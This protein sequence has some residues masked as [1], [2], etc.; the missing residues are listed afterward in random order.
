M[1][2]AYDNMDEYTS[3]ANHPKVKALIEQLVSLNEKIEAF[4][5][6]LAPLETA[7]KKAEKDY[8]SWEE[9]MRQ[10]MRRRRA[11]VTKAASLAE[12]VRRGLDEAKRL[13]VEVN[14]M[15]GA[16]VQDLEAHKR[17]SEAEERWEQIMADHEWLWKE[18]IRPFQV[19]AAKFMASAFDNQLHGVLNADQMG[20][21][22]TLMAEAALDLVQSSDDYDVVMSKRVDGWHN[23]KPM[24]KKAVLWICPN[25]IKVTT[26]NELAKW[27]SNRMVAVLDGPPG[28]RDNIVKIAHAN[29]LTLVVNYETLSRTPAI[30]QKAWPIVVLDEAHTFKNEGTQVFDNVEK[31]C[32]KAGLIY[33]MTGT[34]ITNRP[35]EFWAILHMLTLKGKYEGKFSA[36]W[37]Y[38]NEYCYQ[39]GNVI[40]FRGNSYDRLI[41]NVSNMVIR[42]RKDEVELELP[43]KVREIRFVELPAEQRAIY[44]SMRDKFYVW[45]DEENKEAL[46]A[47]NILAWMTRLRQIALMPAGVKIDH[48]DG[49]SLVLD[50]HESGKIDEAMTILEELVANEEKCLVFAT[51]NEGLR[52]I[53]RRVADRGWTYRGRPIETAGIVGGVNATDKATIV[54]RFNDPEDA[55]AVVVGNVKAMGLGLNLQ[56]AC[57][58]AIF[59]D[60]W[61]SPGVNEQA[62]DRLHRT[63][64]KSAVTIHIIQA[65]ETIDAFIAAKLEEKINMIESIMERKEL[66]K[67][68]DDGLI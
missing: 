46:S 24:E 38:I 4:S 27:N 17:L 40:E 51:T 66:R 54:D 26:R 58:H 7:R 30:L 52:E 62:E 63:G 41:K 1:S 67:A 49:T 12:D 15:V 23:M 37:R 57:S 34:P 29:G 45:L 68:L 55:L 32:E 18:A 48:G 36:K 56:G 3:W 20:L 59:L 61:W 25:S 16:A 2:E 60:L 14:T 39:Y 64:Q 5:A 44:D 19:T 65:E 35:D 11:E 22:K 31:I 8:E 50:C 42:R 28:I 43:D 13:K 9:E 10:E 21:G 47:T 53:Q 33:P 6:N